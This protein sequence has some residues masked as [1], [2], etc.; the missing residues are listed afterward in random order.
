[1][2]ND[3]IMTKMLELERFDLRNDALDVVLLPKD[4]EV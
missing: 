2:Q 4:T 3:E 1:M